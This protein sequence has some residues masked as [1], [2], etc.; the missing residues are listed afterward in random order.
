[1]L[2]QS[3][4]VGSFLL[5][6]VLAGG[7]LALVTG[8]PRMLRSANRWMGA[9]L[10]SSLDGWQGTAASATSVLAV[11]WT[12]L[13]AAGFYSPAAAAAPETVP[14]VGPVA[15]EVLAID[16]WVLIAAIPLA[17][18]LVEGLAMKKRGLALALEVVRGL[19]YLPA[20]ALALAVLFPWTLWERVRRMLRRD[21]QDFHRVFI[22][23]DRYDAVLEW[24]AGRLHDQGLEVQVVPAPIGVRAS[25]WLA[26]HFGPP[27]FRDHIPYGLRALVGDGVGLAVYSSL[28]DLAASKKAI[29]RV[30]CA[31]W[32]QLPPEG[33]WWTRSRA[34]RDLEASILGRYGELPSDV[35]ATLA[36]LEGGPDE[37]RA[38]QLEYLMAGAPRG[39]P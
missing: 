3:G 21:A 34:A 18:G 19:V 28:L 2:D 39:H 37:W 11:F 35:P 20:L 7:L 30:R 36:A 14:G 29:G 12:F 31:L 17:F 1:M 6:L 33:F 10:F 4:E 16:V 26:D 15:R 5:G 23:T 9:V 27:A 8:G 13:L 38:L 32:G 24:I 25:H 22:E